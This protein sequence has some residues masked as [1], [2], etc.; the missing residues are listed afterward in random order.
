[1]RALFFRP[2][3]FILFKTV[4]RFRFYETQIAKLSCDDSELLWYLSKG[5]VKDA[6]QV[7]EKMPSRRDAHGRVVDWTCL[8]TKYSRGGWVDEARV[9]FDIMPERNVVS[10]N[11]MLSGYLRSG[12]LSEGC[13]FFEEMPEKNVVSWTLVLCGLADAGRVEE[14]RRLFE[15]MPERNI[16]SWNSMIGGLVK[17]GD[18]EGAREV[19]ER[20]PVKNVVSCNVMIGGYVERCRMD[21]A[22]GLFDGMVERNVITWTSMVSGYCRSGNVDEGYALFREMPERNVVSWTAMIGG[23]SWNGFCKEALLLFLEMKGDYGTKPNGETFISLVYA[24]AGIGVPQLGMQLHAQLIVNNWDHDDYGGRLSKGL[25]HMYSA[26]G[27]M[28]Y[29]DFLFMKHSNT[30]S[31]QSCN[32]M[33]NGYIHIGKLE[34]AQNLFDR[35]PIRDKISWTSMITGYFSVGEVSKACYL[36]QIMPDKDAISW[37]AMIS[38]HIQN[39][40][41][42][43]A[44]DI[45]FKMRSEGVSPLSSTYSV[46]LGAAGAMSYL[47]SGRQFHGLLTKTHYELDL[48]ISNSLISMYAKCGEIDDAYRAFSNMSFRDLISWNSMIMGFSD[49]GLTDKTLKIFE[50]MVQSG[51]QP[52]SVT[53]LGILSACSHA[54]LV[55]KGWEFINAMSDVY[56]IQPAPEHCICMINLLGRAG[57]VKEAQELVRRLPF[58]PDHAVWGALLGIC[59]FG[60]TNPQVAK[61]AAKQLLEMDPLNAPAHVVLCNI[62]SANGLHIEEKALRREMGLK[63]VRKV[64]GCSWILVQGRVN[65]FLSG[66]ILHPDVGE[67]LLVLFGNMSESQKESST[68]LYV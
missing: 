57:K 26:Y 19:F 66:D 21:E 41:F 9:L 58:K 34:Q 37:T 31:V 51:T 65:V 50:A 3:K 7:L 32:S 56:G 25:I 2:T 44:T 12:R 55:H 18:V 35:L 45:F 68:V 67:M 4:I 43:E 11:A 13:R 1:M 30:H 40:L 46:L 60:K 5:L 63:G 14:A 39:E 47:D 61:Y 54:G 62:Y 23:F 16:V 8:V 15:A 36:F 28:D 20:M 24:C 22:R 17:N 33:I 6:R 48:F 52:N 38:G 29:A 59:G 27:I 64:P 10:Y 53:F 42:A 49:H